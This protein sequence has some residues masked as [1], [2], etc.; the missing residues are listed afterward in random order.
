MHVGMAH[1]YGWAVAVTAS[2]GHRVADRR[3]TELIEP[4]VPAAH[5]AAPPRQPARGTCSKVRG[6]RRRRPLG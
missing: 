2:P 1:H 3:R 4:G 5:S 6:R